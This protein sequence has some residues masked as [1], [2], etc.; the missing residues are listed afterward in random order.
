MIMRPAMLTDSQ[1]RADSPKAKK[2][3]YRVKE[4]LSSPYTVSQK[5]VAHFLVEGLLKRWEHFD[6][7]VEIAY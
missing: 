1:C 5:D 4:S 6:R 2:A 7:V 3:A